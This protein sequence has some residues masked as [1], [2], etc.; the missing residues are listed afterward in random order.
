MFA[1]VDLGS[2]SFHMIVARHKHGELVVI[3]RIR[4]MVRLAAG[5]GDT[6]NLTDEGRERA[7]ESLARFGQRLEEVP[8]SNVR[9]AATNTLRLT[10]NP[11]AFLRDAEAALGHHKPASGLN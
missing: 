9:A 4:E 6:G 8:E 5:L 11:R 7:L 2:N 1:A 10:R 3:D